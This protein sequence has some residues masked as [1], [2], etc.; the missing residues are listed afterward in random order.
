MKT[1]KTIKQITITQQDIIDLV[2]DE[3]FN[4]ELIK[5]MD[6]NQIQNLS[7]SV[8]FELLQSCCRKN[9]SDV[10]KDFKTGIEE[11][12]LDEFKFWFGFNTEQFLNEIK[13]WSEFQF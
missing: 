11:M 10:L 8:T 7:E 6:N 4:L 9:I 12:E 3:L 5:E 2:I 13:S 1:N